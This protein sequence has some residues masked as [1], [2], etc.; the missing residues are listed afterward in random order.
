MTPDVFVNFFAFG[1]RGSCPLKMFNIIGFGVENFELKPANLTGVPIRI[2]S[3]V[4]AG[5]Y[6]SIQIVHIQHVPCVKF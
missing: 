5:V 1:F 4:S 6:N 3:S 2:L